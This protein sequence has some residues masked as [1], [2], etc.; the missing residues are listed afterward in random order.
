MKT[1][2]LITDNVV[3]NLISLSEGNAHEVPNAVDIGDYLVDIGDTYS[4]G[5]FYHDGS[6]VMTFEEYKDRVAQVRLLEEMDAAYK[7]GVNS[8]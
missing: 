2:A 1:Y 7:E 3:V 4:D 5:V 6:E 8:V